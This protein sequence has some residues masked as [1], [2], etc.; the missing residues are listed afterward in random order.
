MNLRVQKINYRSRRFSQD[1]PKRILALDDFFGGLRNTYET[2]YF[3]EMWVK[4]SR[5]VTLKL[6][7]KI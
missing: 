5:G 4:F 6:K 2:V 7:L 3:D 1:S